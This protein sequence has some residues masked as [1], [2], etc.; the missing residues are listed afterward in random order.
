VYFV[1]FVV[2]RDFFSD[3]FHS[4]FVSLYN[5][6]MR[7][8][9]DRFI[10]GFP[11]LFLKQYPYAWIAVVALW[12]RTRP[13]AGLFLVIIV[14]GVLSLR[15]QSAAWISHT[16]REH[17]PGDGKFY[18]DRPAVPWKRAVRNIVILLAGSVVI[19]FLLKGQL[20]LGFWQFFIMIAGFTLFYRDTQFFGA[21]VTYI[22]TDT[23]IA[24]RFVPG[25]IDF[26]L[27]FSFKEINRIEK[28]EYQKE[29]G[30]ELFARTKDVKEGLLLTPKNPNGFTRSIGNVFIVPKDRDGFLEQLPNEYR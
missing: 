25:H 6:A 3:I 20:G 14:I 8:F 13:L 30:W 19:A 1:P 26:R 7:T 29:N 10:L 23:G 2:E 24:I 16:R 11:V 15:W 5:R 22:I 28:S 12:Q 4:K 18:V 27:F 21:A 17:A 9:L